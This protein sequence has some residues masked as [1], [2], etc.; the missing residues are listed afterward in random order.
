MKISKFALL[1][2]AAVIANRTAAQSV[3]VGIN[4]TGA[5]AHSSAMLDVLSTDRGFLAPRM[6]NTQRD[7]IASPA[8]GLLVFQTDGTA[9]F[10]YYD[11]TAWQPISGSST[12]TSPWTVAG[13]DIYNNNTGNVGVGI[14]S[15]LARLHAADNVL[16]SAP[17]YATA[18]TTGSVPVSGAGRRTMWYADKAA[19][20]TG[21]VDGTQWDAANIGN[22]SFASGNNSTASGENA[23]AMG[24]GNGSGISSTAIG[25]DGYTRSTT[26]GNYATAVGGGQASSESTIAI[27]AGTTADA[28]YAT[29]IGGGYANA[30]ANYSLAL[31]GGYT[32]VGATNSTAIGY[33]VTYGAY[34]TAI[35]QNNYGL[36][37]SNAIGDYSIALGGGQASGNNSLAFGGNGT[38]NSTASGN[39]STAMG[40]GLASGINTTAIG[41]DVSTNSHE[42]AFALGDHSS[43]GSPTLNDADNQMMMRFAGGYKLYSDASATVGTQLAPGGSSWSTISDVRK[44][45]N[46]APV[47]GEDFLNK[48]AGFKLTSWNY[49]GQDPKQHRH[50]GPMAQDFY[51]AFG[52]DNY[53]T[54]GNDTTISQAD[55]EGVSFVAIQALVKRT[56]QLQ[57]EVAALKAENK[58]V[59]NQNNVLKAELT[60]QNKTFLTR[61]EMIEA[62]LQ[63]G[64]M[65]TK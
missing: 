57:K 22:Y 6:T 62:E 5:S 53:G 24:G 31:N 2:L 40:G 41:S 16:F 30:H 28:I 35:G 33:G 38:N 65:S 48:I 1:I 25:T 43:V 7:A 32:D 55:M 4:T 27:G 49:K 45:E 56:E 18:T 10:Y 36:Y 9:G 51:A 3:G 54:V 26:T 20:R 37:N 15:P 52:R 14:T 60:E 23:T 61:L 29:A 59:T 17:G 12:G 63:K 58:T 19:F 21:G 50:Y 42:G 11:G 34:S 47:N 13:T 39:Y 8:T 64:K 44:K 46:F